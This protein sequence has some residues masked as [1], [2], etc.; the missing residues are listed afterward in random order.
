[1]KKIAGML[2]IV[3]LT[4]TLLSGCANFTRHDAGIVGGAAAGGV[5]GNVVTGGSTLGTAVSW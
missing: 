4:T 5:V 1:M 2:S 3:V